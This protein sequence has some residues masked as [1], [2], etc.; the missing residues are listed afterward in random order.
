MCKKG[1]KV[2]QKLEDVGEDWDEDKKK[3]KK[4][5]KKTIKEKYTADEELSKTKRIWTGNPDD[6]SQ[7]EYNEVT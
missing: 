7:E 3:E 4:K 2:N 1:T 5:T 6:V